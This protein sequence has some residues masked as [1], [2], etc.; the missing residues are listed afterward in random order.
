VLDQ[1]YI[2]QRRNELYG[3]LNTG[4]EIHWRKKA[5]FFLFLFSAS[6]I[7]SLIFGFFSYLIKPVTEAAGNHDG[8]KLLQFSILIILVGIVNC[9][10]SYLAAI[11]NMKLVKEY[12]KDL[13]KDTF[14]K[15][16]M[17]KTSDFFKCN[18]NEYLSTLDVDV[19]ILSQNLLGNVLGIYSVL[20][21]FIF[22]V[23]AVSY[24]DWKVAIFVMIFSMV[25]VSMPK[26]F[27]N[28]LN[29]KTMLYSSSFSKFLEKTK[30]CLDGF[31]VLKSFRVESQ[32]MKNFSKQS[33]IV[34]LQDIEK[35]RIFYRIG[36][37]SMGLSQITFLG[38]V[39]L[40]SFMVFSGNME[41]G[42]IL[43]LSQMI[44]G[45]IAPLEGLPKQIA[46]VKSTEK[47]YE[48]LQDITMAPVM[49]KN[50]IKVKK[51]NN[52]L[53]VQQVS[54]SYNSDNDLFQDLDIQ[55]DSSKKYVIVGTNG[56]GKST[57]VKLL[58]KFYSPI[59]GKICWNGEDISTI[60]DEE[61]YGVVAYQ[62][63]DIFLFD[64]TLEYNITLGRECS[65]ENLEQIISSCGLTHVVANLELGLDTVVHE[66]GNILSGGERQRI[67]IARCMVEKPKMII[68]DES[69]A[70]LDNTVAL[71]IEDFIIG[72]KDCGCIIITHHFHPTIFKKCDCI[73][74][75][76][77]GKV[78]E[79]GNFYDLNQPGK[80]F[81]SLM[82][83]SS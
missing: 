56:S 22:S 27:G 16:M 46:G 6:A 31:T 24:L 48:K 4:I 67:G 42:F 74:C 35:E 11:T 72:M 77:K 73:L 65:K 14:K 33:H 26:L 68:L 25:S 1:G 13:R 50:A 58:M 39:F 12:E 81:Y 54:F 43:A 49:G 37:L 28:S 29:E 60:S 55:F 61:Y 7:R 20:W 71:Q 23:S 51:N 32:A 17:Q 41:V 63:Q 82:E 9:L 19:K 2:V 15:I 78:I 59:K 53:S 64:D 10:V 3:V 62:Q 8:R 45:I 83:E 70:N 76:E 38:V 80:A 34:T 69:F 40:G 52:F 66:N 5:T 30:D 36:Y 47:L 21:S 57:L 44:G 79:K 75:M 18:T